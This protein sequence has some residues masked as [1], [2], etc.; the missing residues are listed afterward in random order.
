M[1]GVKLPKLG[2]GFAWFLSDPWVGEDGFYVHT[3]FI[4]RKGG[5]EPMY[6]ELPLGW[7]NVVSGEVI[8]GDGERPAQEMVITLYAW[9]RDTYNVK[10]TWL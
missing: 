6:T 3:L 5:N 1:N 2:E 8:P 4:L 9:Y 7:S 10:G